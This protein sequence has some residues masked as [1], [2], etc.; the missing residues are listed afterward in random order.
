MNVYLM[1]KDITVAELF[2]TST[3]VHVLQIFNNNH[4]PLGVRNVPESMIDI[5]MERWLQDRCIP[6]AQPNY[7]LLMQKAGV[8]SVMEM[9]E[10]SY[11]CSLTDCY[12]FKP[13]L[14]KVTWADVNFY[15]NGFDESAGRV[16]LNGDDTIEIDNWNVPEL[17]TN[18][19]LPKRWFQGQHGQFYL[20]KAGTPP[21]H[22]EVYNEAFVSQ[23]AMLFGMDVV[24]YAIY[25][26][27]QFDQVYSI[28][29]SFIHD[30]HEEFVSLEQLRHSLGGSKQQTLDYLYELGFDKAIDEARGLDY[31]V[32]NIDRHFGNL[33]IIRDPD[34][35]EIKRLA[36]LFDHGFSMVP[37][38]GSPKRE[39]A[40]TNPA[41]PSPSYASAVALSSDGFIQKLT[42]NTDAEELVMLDH[43]EWTRE[44]GVAPID[45]M[46]R[47]RE[48]YK[49]VYPPQ[50][51]MKLVNSI[52]RRLYDLQDRAEQLAKMEREIEEALE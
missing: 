28:C 33:G 39:T 7:S 16:T 20:L 37:E 51:L 48:T 30:D 29:P 31:L 10:K 45:I 50:E 1:H 40:F 49:D 14:D 4:M 9:P 2:M 3:A 6:K 17:T 42:G 8:S 21:D 32:K 25:K 22:I 13:I 11:L 35:L 38:D 34:T 44:S 19:V 15:D 46:R 5:R 36:P 23:C 43:L 47:V 12:W 27:A 24:P 41:E 52:G 26:D 18:G